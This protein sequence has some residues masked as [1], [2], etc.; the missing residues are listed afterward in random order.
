MTTVVMMAAN[1]SIAL[2]EIKSVLTEGQALG[3]A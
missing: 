3:L 1:W 2:A